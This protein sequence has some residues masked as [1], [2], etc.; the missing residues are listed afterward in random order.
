MSPYKSKEDYN[1]YQREYQRKM[2]ADAEAYRALC[3]EENTC[4]EEKMSEGMSY[5]DAKTACEIEKEQGL[6]MKVYVVEHFVDYEGGD[7][8][9]VYLKEED[10]K[11]RCLEEATKEQ[12][13]REKY[14]EPHK[15][16]KLPHG[17]KYRDEG[18]NYTEFKVKEKLKT[19]PQSV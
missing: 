16:E 2:R 7:A 14:S 12:S 11:Q 19:S 17:F 18:W 15:I 1:A 4:I 6:N 13:Q 3:E 5:D 10:A 9:D 8:I